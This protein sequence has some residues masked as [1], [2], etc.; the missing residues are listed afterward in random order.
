M[1]AGALVVAV[2]VW[3]QSQIGP[4]AAPEAEPVT[5]M[6]R[7]GELREIILAD[8]S[9]VTLN[10]A[11][12]LEVAFSQDERLV[13][14]ES[15][16]AL[17]DVAAGEVPFTV[18]AAGRRTTALGT[19]FDVYLMPDGLVV[20]LVEGVVR[21]AG[22]G[23]DTGSILAPGEQ[24]RVEHGKVSILPVDMA[25]VTGWQTGMVQFRDATLAEAVAE[26]NRYSEVKLR[27][28][29][30]DL[31][32]ERLS[33]VFTTGDQDLFLESLSLYLPVVTEQSGDEILIRRRPE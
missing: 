16:Q 30:P 17:F 24:L 29:D 33:G 1:T 27:V 19:R 14:L 13:R 15:G 3:T 6:T 22:K 8:G 11:T 23:G 18:E 9:A 32:A 26:L 10:T 7:I 20:T 2:I 5:Y 21:V 4:A 25:A 12:R 28:D 31:A